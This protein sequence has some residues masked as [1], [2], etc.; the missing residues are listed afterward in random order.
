M[1]NKAMN[2]VYSP[3]HLSPDGHPWSAI[4]F[5]NDVYLGATHFLEMMSQHFKLGSDMTCAWDHAGKWFYDGWVGRDMAGDLFTPFPVPEEEQNLPQK[6]S[7]LTW[8]RKYSLSFPSLSNQL[9]PSSPKTKARHLKTLPYQVFSAWNGIAVLSPKPFMPPH[10]VKFR[11][12]I[13]SGTKGNR[14]GQQC[15]ASEASLICEDFWKYGF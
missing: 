15:Q 10:N 1:R 5:Y 4:V 13:P 8:R 6:V 11:R 14:N 7:H 2:P 12:A 9:F 3:T